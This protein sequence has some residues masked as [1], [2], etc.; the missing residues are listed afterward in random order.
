MSPTGTGDPGVTAHTWLPA[1]IRAA[2]DLNPWDENCQVTSY[3]GGYAAMSA[4]RDSLELAITEA[5]AAGNIPGKCGRVYI[6]DWRFN[7]LRDLSDNNAWKLAPWGA[8]L[9]AIRRP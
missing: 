2:A 8:T 1:P 7:S 4:I 3:V 6:T 5:A 9:P